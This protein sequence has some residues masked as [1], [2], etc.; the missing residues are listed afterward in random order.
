M[1]FLSDKV[2]AFW[3][4]PVLFSHLLL[5]R[6]SL[7][8]IFINNWQWKI[9]W[10][11]QFQTAGERGRGMRGKQGWLGHKR[12]QENQKTTQQMFEKSRKLHIWVC[13]TICLKWVVLPR[14]AEPPMSSIP[15]SA[16]RT[17]SSSGKLMFSLDWLWC[18]ER[19]EKE[20]VS[21][22]WLLSE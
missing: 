3:V 10:S 4:L 15:P 2:F 6:Y 18:L 13:V 12:S 7:I 17:T 11:H 19:P 1:R 9:W 22:A 21:M 5:Y 8:N 14:L 16:E 20:T